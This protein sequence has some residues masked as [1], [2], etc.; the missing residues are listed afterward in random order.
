MTGNENLKQFS[1]MLNEQDAVYFEGLVNTTNSKVREKIL[2]TANDRMATILT[3]IWDRQKAYYNNEKFEFKNNNKDKMIVTNIGAFTGNID[4]TRNL[5]KTS[6]GYSL[7][8]L[9]NKRQAIINSYRGGISQ[10]EGDYIS[11]QMYGTYNSPAYISST[12]SPIGNINIA[13]RN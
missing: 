4:A 10:K 1:K 3:A 7:S 12:I 11:A 9:D 2:N 8:K 5:L 13:R 6:Y